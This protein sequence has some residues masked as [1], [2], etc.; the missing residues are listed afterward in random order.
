M[1]KESVHV[2][3]LSVSY[4]K[5]PVLWSVDFRLPTGVFAAIVGPNGA[6]KSTLLKSCVGLLKPATGYVE[7][8]D[9]QTLKQAQ[10]KIAYLPQRESVDWHFPISVREVVE[11]GTLVLEPIS[12]SQRESVVEKA[13]EDV[14]LTSF[15]DRQISD[16]SGGQQQRVFIARALAQGADLFFLDEPF[17][18]IDAS[19]EKTII[20]VLR[21]L[22]DQGKTV[23]AVMHD[24]FSVYENVDRLVLINTRLI[25]EGTKKEV[26]TAENLKAAYGGQLDMLSKI[27]HLVE[28]SK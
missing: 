25:A 11:M 14:A 16:L 28:D 20:K 15:A 9:N 5:K 22:V 8:F 7:F 12:K 2:H 23:I 21:K 17:A 1:T 24:L 13:L 27:L 18:A 4:S 3:S 26:F 19:T 6:G 10:K